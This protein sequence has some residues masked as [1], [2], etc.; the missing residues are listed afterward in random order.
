M[1]HRHRQFNVAHALAS[2]AR[3][4]HFHAA[5]VADYTAMLDPLVLAAGTFPVLNRTK[6]PLAK[7]PTLLWLECSVVDGLRVLDFTLGPR[8]YGVRG[9]HGDGDMIHM[10]YLVEP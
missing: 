6:N 5:A 10:V 2:D 3:L 1:G 8:P 7:K 4:G 9:S